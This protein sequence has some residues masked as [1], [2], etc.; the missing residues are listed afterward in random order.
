MRPLLEGGEVRAPWRSQRECSVV[1]EE[2]SRLRRRWK[3][4]IR[5][6]SSAGKDRGAAPARGPTRERDP[7]ARHAAEGAIGPPQA[8]AFSSGPKRRPSSLAAGFGG[9]VPQRRAAAVTYCSSSANCLKK[10]CS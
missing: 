9:A 6:K 5:E 2:L 8:I 10:S 7:S 1:G 3:G 4:A